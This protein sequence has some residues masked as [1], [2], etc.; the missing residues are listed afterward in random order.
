MCDALEGGG[1]GSSG[2]TMTASG[3]T[4]WLMRS[5]APSRRYAPG[6]H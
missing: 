5:S 3:R 2:I 6:G 4:C 1:S